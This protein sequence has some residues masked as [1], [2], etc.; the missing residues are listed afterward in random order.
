MKH[1]P[2]ATLEPW[3]EPQGCTVQGRP[4]PSV[5]RPL[6][7]SQYP[8]RAQVNEG[9]R[10]LGLCAGPMAGSGEHLMSVSVAAKEPA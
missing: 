6:C 8:R 4:R 10:P 9:Q 2:E 5:L 1:T 3:L 7:A